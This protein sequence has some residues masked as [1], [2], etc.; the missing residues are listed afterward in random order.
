MNKIVTLVMIGASI[1]VATGC[2]AP[3]SSPLNVN[4]VGPNKF[5]FNP[6]TINPALLFE[7]LSQLPQ[8]GTLNIVGP[9]ISFSAQRNMPPGYVAQPIIPLAADR[10][11][12]I[13]NDFFASQVYGMR[14]DHSSQDITLVPAMGWTITFHLAYP[15]STLNG[16]LF[17]NTVVTPSITNSVVSQVLTK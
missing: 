4:P 17:T 10:V 6:G 12:L 13:E 1:F 5:G 14:N 16:G 15:P 8:S 2:I 9:G 3:G 7:A 11:T